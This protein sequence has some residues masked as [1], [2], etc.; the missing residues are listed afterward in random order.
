MDFY[1]NRSPASQLIGALLKVGTVFEEK[2]EKNKYIETISCFWL[3]GCFVKTSGRFLNDCFVKTSGRFLS[4]CF[5]KTSG[6]FLINHWWRFWD[7]YC[8][9]RTA[10]SFILII[11]NLINYLLFLIKRWGLIFQFSA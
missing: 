3:S 8:K 7:I 2:E 9:L 10:S 1:E 11:L 6:C 5:V 4:G